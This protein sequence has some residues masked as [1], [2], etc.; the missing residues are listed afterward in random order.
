MK[1]KRLTLEIFRICSGEAQTA[2]I[3]EIYLNIMNYEHIYIYVKTGEYIEHPVPTFVLGKTPEETKALGIKFRCVGVAEKNPMYRETIKLNNPTIGPEDMY[4]SVESFLE[5]IKSPGSR[6]RTLVEGSGV[7]LAVTG[8][9][10]NPYSTKRAKRFSSGNIAAHSMH[11]TT[12]TSVVEM[13]QE[14]EPRAGIT[15][16]VQGFCM[17]TSSEDTTTPYER[18]G[19]RC[20]KHQKIHGNN[21]HQNVIIKPYNLKSSSTN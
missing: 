14:V 12:L 6:V 1:E 13:Y 21:T 20:L 4:D 2:N 8:S 5:K 11:G 9:P 16:Q 18:P 7:G 3:K 10:C 17:S 15:E 19:L